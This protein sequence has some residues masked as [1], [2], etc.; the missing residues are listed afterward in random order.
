MPIDLANYPESW[1]KISLQ[2]KEEQGWKCLKCGKPHGGLSDRGTKIILTT[3]HKDG[4]PQNNERE[5]LEA[6]CQACH[7]RDD[8][9]RHVEHARKTRLKKNGKRLLPF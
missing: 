6:L 1:H 8:L 7:L 4:N 5:N 2:V 3:H 9:D